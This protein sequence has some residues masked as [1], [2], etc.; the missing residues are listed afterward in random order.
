MLHERQYA[1]G[2]LG[3]GVNQGA[4]QTVRGV[5]NIFP[6]DLGRAEDG[7]GSFNP[8]ARVVVHPTAPIARKFGDR[9][10]PQRAVEFDVAPDE[11]FTVQRYMERNG[12]GSVVVSLG[13][14]KDYNDAYA[15]L[16]DRVPAGQRAEIRIMVPTRTDVFAIG[17]DGEDVIIG[18][19]L[20]WQP[21][22]IADRLRLTETSR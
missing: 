1:G 16:M 19:S 6:K 11:F 15:A 5:T 10:A 8:G 14:F 13:S 20:T 4:P 18:E 12:A 3:A 9:R 17:S 21:Q 7:N 2:L 22:S